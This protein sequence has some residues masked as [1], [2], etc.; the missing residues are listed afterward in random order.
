MDLIKQK[1]TIS[2]QQ[3]ELREKLNLVFA[4][5]FKKGDNTAKT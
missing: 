2:K 1:A 3:L 5:S 4:H